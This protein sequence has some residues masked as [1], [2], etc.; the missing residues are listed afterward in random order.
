MAHVARDVDVRQEVHFDLHKAVAAAGLAA[1]ALDVERE[2]AGAVAAGL[3]VSRGGEQ[4]AD[5]GKQARIGRGVRARRA[6]DGALVDDDCLVEVLDALE[7]VV[8]AGADARTVQ[9]GREL[10]ADDLVDE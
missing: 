7:A 2:A 4:V 1:A 3:C 8:P 10:F 6:A 9:H 5:V